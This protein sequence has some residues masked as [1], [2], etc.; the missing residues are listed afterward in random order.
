[1]TE[2]VLAYRTLTGKLELLPDAL[3]YKGQS[4]PY[5]TVVHLGRY[6]RTTS[7]NFIPMSNYLRIR[8][9]IESI[10]KPIT[11]SNGGIFTAS[12]KRIYE[13]LVKKTFETRSEKYLR[14]ITS[15]GCFDYG[16]AKFIP[17]N[18]ILINN[19][20][21]NLRAAKVSLESFELVVKEPNGMF[22]KK[23]RIST[24]IDQDIFL[25]M[26]QRF[27]GITLSN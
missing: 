17:P 11:I 3:R 23:R 24:E 10:D 5:A 9:Y 21:I 22:A 16:G 8:I 19:H 20:M 12:L 4:Y 27:Y 1:M 2:E 25:V 15:N 26:L 6:A 13:R 7:V 18:E 14:Q